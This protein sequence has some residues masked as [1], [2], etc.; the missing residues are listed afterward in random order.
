[1]PLLTYRPEALV[2]WLVAL[3]FVLLRKLYRFARPVLPVAW[4]HER[5]RPCVLEA[6]FPP[7]MVEEVISVRTVAG[8]PTG[9][10]LEQVQGLLGCGSGAVRVTHI[11][12]SSAFFS[13][14]HLGDIL[15]SINGVFVADGAE[16]ATILRDAADVRVRVHRAD[17]T[18]IA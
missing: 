16:A 15:V 9:I 3:P 4:V 14:L 12:R 2:L 8:Q 7:V 18:G 1:M 10:S 6:L 17:K 13:L 5:I 11:D